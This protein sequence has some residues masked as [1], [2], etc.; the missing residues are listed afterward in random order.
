[1]F[2]NLCVHFAVVSSYCLAVLMKMR[3]RAFVGQDTQRE[4]GRWQVGA[5]EGAGGGPGLFLVGTG[6]I[7]GG[8]RQ[9]SPQPPRGGGVDSRQTRADQPPLASRAVR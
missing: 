9:T 5:W 1:M 2:Q 7:A 8:G 3:A 6:Y 4:F